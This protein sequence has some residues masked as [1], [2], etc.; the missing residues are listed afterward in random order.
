M[1]KNIMFRIIRYRVRKI[2]PVVNSKI[3]NKMFT[4][5]YKFF[6][7]I[8]PSQLWIIVLALLNKTDLK[9]LISIPSIFILFNSIVS[10]T[11]DK[12]NLNAK[13]LYTKLEGQGLTSSDNK[14][15]LFFWVVI[16]LAIIKRFIMSVFKLLWIPFKIAF[17]YFILKYF[18]FDFNSAYNTLNNLSL[19]VVDW[20]YE[21]IINFFNLFNNNDK[22]N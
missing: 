14:L 2:L 11:N 4:L 22:N 20:F 17:I 12:G 19:G 15:E 7:L 5:S 3:F 10:D 6:T 16:I 9:N 13:S 1:I 8:K 21:K 18:G